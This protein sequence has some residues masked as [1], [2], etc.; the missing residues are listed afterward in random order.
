MLA[1]PI[2]V[3]V[4]S[5]ELPEIVFAQNNSPEKTTPGSWGH[6]KYAVPKD[7]HS[8]NFQEWSDNI[9]VPLTAPEQTVSS[10]QSK[11]MDWATPECPQGMVHT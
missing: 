1:T 3:Y 9:P 4:R 11:L 10:L 8:L 6:Q 2:K 5:A 7:F